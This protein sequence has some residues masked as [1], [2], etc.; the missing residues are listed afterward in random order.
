MTAFDLRDRIPYNWTME[1]RYS[2]QTL[3]A[4][5]AREGQERIRSSRVVVVGCGALGSVASEMFARGGVGSLTLVDRDFVEWSNLQRQSLYTETDAAEGIPKAVAA[6]R[7]L[8]AVNSEIEIRGLVEDL[9]FENVRGIC[10]EADLIVDGSDNFEVRF[11]INDFAV[12]N[13]IPWLYG[14]A[15]GS[16][17]LAMAVVPGKTACLR[18]LFDKPPTPGTG[19]T[20]DTAGILAA[21]IHVV[22]AFQ[23][24]QGLRLMVGKDPYRGLLQVDVWNDEWR[25]VS[26][27]GPVEGC[28][29]C[30]KGQYEFLSSAS[31]SS[32]SRL[33]GRNAVQISP[34]ERCRLDLPD[35]GLRLGKSVRVHSNPHL[36]RIFAERHEI[37]LF[38]DGRAIIKGT[39]DVAEARALYARYVG[40]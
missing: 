4:G 17:G 13:G 10:G 38:A 35:L 29:C 31:Q 40:I 11:L 23:V 26:V 5:I 12:E 19:D 20:C 39:N 30:G 22:A 37:A 14:A 9:T 25:R 15:V 27:E 2:R 33:C 36:L 3:F 24:T 7:A 1:D 6:E 34:A 32:T 21:V 16:Y 28:L 8:R 18:C